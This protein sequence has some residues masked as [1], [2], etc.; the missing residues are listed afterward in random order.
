MKFEIGEWHLENNN[1]EGQSDQVDQEDQVEQEDQEDQED[2]DE[3]EKVLNF[4]FLLLD[5]FDCFVLTAAITL[6]NNLRG[7]SNNM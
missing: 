3:G 4:N 2:Q 6:E 7:H 1:Q 5:T